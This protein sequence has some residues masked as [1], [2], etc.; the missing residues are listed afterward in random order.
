MRQRCAEHCGPAQCG[1]Q[2]GYDLYFNPRVG[3]CQLQQWAGHTIDPR[4]A[5]ADQRHRL[6]ALRRLQRP[7]AAV[8]LL[9][10][11][12]GADFLA[13]VARTDQLNIDRISAQD[14]RRIQRGHRLRCQELAVPGAEAHHIHHITVHHLSISNPGQ[15]GAAQRQRSHRPAPIS[16][17]AASRL[18]T[19][20]PP[21]RIHCQPRS[22]L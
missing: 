3:G 19:A 20:P 21:V 13:G 7:A 16:A 6:A 12:C 2:A 18:R 9:R 4:I 17:E 1:S 10:H 22:H 11:A 5:G 14:I 8:D 15:R